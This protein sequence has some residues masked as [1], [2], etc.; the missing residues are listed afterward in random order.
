M[1][2][3]QAF[4]GKRCDALLAP[5]SGFAP[6]KGALPVID[7]YGVI[8]PLEFKG[9]RFAF[10]FQGD[11][12]ACKVMDVVAL[13][14]A[15]HANAF[16]QCATFEPTLSGFGMRYAGKKPVVGFW[17]VA[18]DKLMRQPASK[19]GRDI[20]CQEPEGGE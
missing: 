12:A 17:I 14:D 6:P 19:F 16:L 9:A 18:G 2:A 7:P 5:A 4:V 8:R 10:L 11:G 1:A 3:A 20:R 15:A 13:P